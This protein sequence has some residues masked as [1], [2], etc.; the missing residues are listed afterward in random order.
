MNEIRPPIEP[1]L[2]LALTATDLKALN[3]MI[4]QAPPEASALVLFSAE[5][6]VVLIGM[7]FAGQLSNWIMTPAATHDDAKAM[8]EAWTPILAASAQRL[9]Y[10]EAADAVERARKAH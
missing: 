10:L 7:L 1:A 4:D 3:A 9:G 5:R 8:G 2:A 6:Q